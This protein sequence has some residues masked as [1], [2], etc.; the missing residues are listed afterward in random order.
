[1][2]PPAESSLH[3]LDYWRVVKV[4][5]FVILTVILLV[6]ASATIYTFNTPKQYV[7]VA[8]MSVESD[9]PAVSVYGR[10]LGGMDMITF[11]TQFEIIQ[12]KE[13][14]YPVVEQLKLQQRWGSKKGGGADLPRDI[15]YY[16]LK[17]KIQLNVA[18]GTTVIEIRGWSE[19]KGEAAEIANAVAQAYEKYRLDE[20]YNEVN[21]GLQKI[22]EEY[23]RQQED[24]RVA[25]EKVEQLRKDLNITDL[26]SVSLLTGGGRLEQEEL[27]R[28]ESEL[29]E[30]KTALKT[31]KLRLENLAKLD[32]RE[33]KDTINFLQPEG[34]IP[35]LIS[36]VM[37][38]ERTMETLKASELGP[39][40]PDVIKAKKTYETLKAQL[41]GQLAGVMRAL[42][43]AVDEQEQKVKLLSEDVD[44]LRAREQVSHSAKYT[45]F[46]DA[47]RNL[48]NQQTV[49]E[50]INARL[51]Q[52]RIEIGL[53]R[54]PVR[55]IDQ[56]EPAYAPS[57]PNVP[58]NISI[59]VVVGIVLGVAM[60][61]FIEYLDT[62][63]HRVDDVEK[64]LRIPVLGVVPR[65]VKPLIQ[66]DDVSP[67]AE[68]YR[69]LRAN[70]EF[71]RKDAQANSVT[72]CSG[73]A[74]EGKSTTLINT[75]YIYAQHGQTVL[76]VDSDVRRPSLHRIFG[77]DNKT[78]LT[79][80]ILGGVPVEQ[81]IQAT[82]VPNIHFIPSG[83]YQSDALGILAMGRMRE[84]IGN[85]K[86]RYDMVF[87]DSPPVLGISDA[88]ILAR[89]VDLAVLVIQYRRYPRQL[90]LR[91]QAAL[92]KAGVRLLGA[93]LNQVKS[94]EE[95]Y[96][97]YNY[98]Y[99]YGEGKYG[100][101]GDRS[102]DDK[103]PEK[104]SPPPSSVTVAASGK[105]GKS[106][107]KGTS[108]SSDL[109]ETF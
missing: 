95:D 75:A 104:T 86:Q 35:G 87:F 79:D 39:N 60:A 28:K 103:T 19:D 37:D 105:P 84:L 44:K 63:I 94:E 97:Y 24:V 15:A 11:A 66:L 83:K 109:V 29:F 18:R 47:M 34:N 55:I 3:F 74:G 38:A 22:Q 23:T 65:D 61:F 85:L 69:V 82:S 21:R 40:H 100:Y 32:L 48:E 92:E 96:Y 58:L 26:G 77:V 56:A 93:V 49:L 45:P 80:V 43:I 5:K 13:V 72:F 6:T 67:F 50:N 88:P 70:I 108:S 64:Y 2:N 1:M 101:G 30:A 102:R 73:G 36:A 4:H 25:R 16:M 57:K 99:Y 27:R 8:R 62:S 53:P 33:L 81:V 9:R 59:S 42:K 76:V 17:S 12:S 7:S 89:E 68:F 91:A 10:D 52:E 78:G 31:Q 54:R 98:Y 46:V 14:L 90:A 107:R 51:K 20:K 71:A 106:G 41:D